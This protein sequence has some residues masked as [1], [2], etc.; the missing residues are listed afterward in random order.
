MPFFRSM[1]ASTHE[2]WLVAE[3]IF[4]YLNQQSSSPLRP[5]HYHWLQPVCCHDLLTWFLESREKHLNGK[6]PGLPNL[7]RIGETFEKWAN[8]F[9]TIYEPHLIRIS[10]CMNYSNFWDIRVF[11][12]T[13]GITWR[14]MWPRDHKLASSAV[15]HECAQRSQQICS[16]ESIGW[17]WSGSA[18]LSIFLTLF[19]V[20]I[21]STGL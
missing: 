15:E 21:Y 14:Y 10:C 2:S 16:T 9:L 8:S 18:K 17:E 5:V 1:Y 12:R 11:I 4:T 3:S 6:Q 19:L 13:H 7:F 20:P